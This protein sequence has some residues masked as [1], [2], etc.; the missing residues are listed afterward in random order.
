MHLLGVFLLG[1]VPFGR[2]Y[3]LKSSGP[4]GGFFAPEVAQKDQRTGAAPVLLVYI[5]SY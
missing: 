5:I 3:T 1:K 2:T 4:A